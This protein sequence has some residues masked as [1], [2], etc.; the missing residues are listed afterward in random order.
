MFVGPFIL[1]RRR[2]TAS[3]V[4]Q[5]ST[6]KVGFSSWSPTST[7]WDAHS[8]KLTASLP[9]KMDG[10]NTTFL[11]GRPIFRCYVSFREG[12]GNKLSRN[13]RYEVGHQSDT[14]NVDCQSPKN[15]PVISKRTG[16]NK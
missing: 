11:L 6:Q 9:L 8:L 2:F 14:M 10:W 16:P 1:K 15:Y 13:V 7:S 12:K 4:R 5:I 3:T